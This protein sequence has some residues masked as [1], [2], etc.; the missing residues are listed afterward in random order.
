MIVAIKRESNN[1]FPKFLSAKFLKYFDGRKSLYA[2]NFFTP[3]FAKVNPAKLNFDH[4]HS[5]KFVPAKISTNKAAIFHVNLPK[6]MTDYLG[7]V[8]EILTF[9]NKVPR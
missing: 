5:Q 6:G 7:I 4:D 8:F 2:L 3:P 9:K 1:C